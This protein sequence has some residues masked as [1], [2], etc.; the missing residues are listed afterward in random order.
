MIISA[1]ANGE[2]IGMRPI[3][4]S[5]SKAF[6]E[7][8]ALRHVGHVWRARVIALNQRQR[9]REIVMFKRA[10]HPIDGGRRGAGFARRRPPC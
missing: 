6:E 9:K 3:L 10:R 8:G 4:G 5:A 2:Q 7:Y 1:D